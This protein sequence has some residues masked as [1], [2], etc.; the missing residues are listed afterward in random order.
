MKTQGHD[1]TQAGAQIDNIPDNGTMT[2][3]WKIDFYGC[4]WEYKLDKP[5]N[6]DDQ[7]PIAWIIGDYPNN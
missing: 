4:W 5:S 6:V 3:H 2:G 1:K 7:K